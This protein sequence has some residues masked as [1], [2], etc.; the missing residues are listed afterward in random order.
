MRRGIDEILD[1]CIEMIENDGKTT[2]DC[3]RM[4]KGRRDELEPLLRT[5]VG[6]INAAKIQP[7][8]KR[9]K[10]ARER[11]L[12]AVEIKRWEAGVERLP[13]KMRT[14]HNGKRRW[15][16]A[17]LRLGII[18]VIFA[19]LS[20][21]TLA[22]AQ[23]SLPGSPFYPV[24]LAVEKARIGLARDKSTKAKLYLS[25]AKARIGELS[26]LRKLNKLKKGDKH[27]SELVNA[28]VAN[29]EMAERASG[30]K[31]NRYLKDALSKLAR[32]NRKVFMDTLQKAPAGARPAIRQA[33]MDTESENYGES[34]SHE[35][36]S[37]R[38]YKDSEN[39]YKLEDKGRKSTSSYKNSKKP[40]TKIQDDSKG[41]GQERRDFGS[42]G[43]S[44]PPSPPKG[45]SEPPQGMPGD[46]SGSQMGQDD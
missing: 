43:D 13:D 12:T 10:E 46:S 16:V 25:S 15:Q 21:A 28:I 8:E 44:A 33:L 11:L 34:R 2:D 3:L 4:F 30:K 24:K 36:N 23:D 35:S 7:D 6:L 26:K 38:V 41:T 40:K 29:I 32:N 42:K 37:G 27:Y 39:S 17:L 31:D 45:E 20:G 1:E 22:M 18:A 5:A 19:M 9:R 14:K